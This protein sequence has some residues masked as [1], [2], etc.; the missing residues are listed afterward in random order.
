M[1]FPS[2]RIKWQLSKDIPEVYIVWAEIEWIKFE[3]DGISFYQKSSFNNFITTDISTQEQKEKLKATV[4]E[5]ATKK[6]IKLVA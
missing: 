2:E 3:K 5:I 1:R 4:S 6:N